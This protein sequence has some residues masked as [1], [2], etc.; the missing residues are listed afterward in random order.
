MRKRKGTNIEDINYGIC[1]DIVTIGGFDKGLLN[2]ILSNV[3]DP[4]IPEI[5]KVDPPMM[6]V[7]ITPNISPF[8]GKA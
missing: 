4:K 3:K 2:N 5:T 8:A 7:T 6:F 1:G